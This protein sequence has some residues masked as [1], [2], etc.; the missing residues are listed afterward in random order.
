MGLEVDPEDKRDGV[1]S[2]SLE[3]FSKTFHNSV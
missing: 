1:V 2:F 3:N